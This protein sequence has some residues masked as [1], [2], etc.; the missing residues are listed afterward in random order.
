MHSKI[1]IS[2]HKTV[3]ITTI[4]GAAGHAKTHY[5]AQCIL[6]AVSENKYFMVLTA[7]HSALNN[8]Y[9][10]CNKLNETS[11]NGVSLSKSNFKTIYSYFR[12][13]YNENTLLGTLTPLANIIFIDEFSLINKGLFKSI[14]SYLNYV[15]KQSSYKAPNLKLIIAGDPLQLN[16]IYIEKQKISFNKLHQIENILRRNKPS[17]RLVNSKQIN[18]KQDSLEQSDTKQATPENTHLNTDNQTNLR[19][20][21]D[22][23]TNLRINTLEHFYLTIFGIKAIQNS[24]KIELTK[25]YRSGDLV[26]KTLNAIYSQDKSFEYKFVGMSDVI[27]MLANENYVFLASKY[28]IIQHVYD[29]LSK[30]LYEN[31][32]IEIIDIQQL[33]TSKQALKQL[34]LYSGMQIIV[35]ETSSTKNTDS[36]PLYYNGEELT[37]TGNIDANML[38]CINDKQEIVLIKQCFEN[39]KLKETANLKYSDNP[40]YQFYPVSPANMLTIHKSQGRGFDNVIVCIDDLFDISM[41]YTAITRARHNICFYST[42]PN[43]LQTLFRNAYIE[44]FKQLKTLLKN[45]LL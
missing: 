3:D 17:A 2:E 43:K 29:Y 35:T 34:H 9:N 45:M 36:E 31:K 14:Y 10:T 24:K 5:L 37:F 15:I 8:V 44:D 12:I 32:N 27:N 11:K 26:I 22:N 25:N 21:N 39:I 19:S 20:C 13:D 33:C 42:N 4:F 16:A 18:D 6:K 23:Q 7:T 38:R 40:Q 41:L 30:Y 1:A 28:K